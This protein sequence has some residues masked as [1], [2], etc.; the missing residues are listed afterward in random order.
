MTEV[1]EFLAKGGWLMVP[2]AISSVVALA[3]FLERLWSLQRARVL[4]PRF[5]EVMEK[6]LKERRYEEAAALCQGNDS[7]ISAVLG[8]ALRYSGRDREVVKEVMEESGQREVYFMERFVGALGAI[9]TVTP[10]MG[11]LGTVVGMITVFQRVVNQ[12]SAGQAADAGALANGIWEA[13]I[14]TAAGLTVAIPAYLA[15]RYI[16]SVIDRY[17]VEM[18]DVSLSMAEYIVPEA[19]APVVRF[20][21]E[22]AGS[23]DK[24]EDEGEPDVEPD[25]E[26]AEQEAS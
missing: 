18:V 15:Y 10:L 12:A 14:T 13:L 1:Y 7:H 25:E 4:P 5:L 20:E 16:Q 19:Q 6:L 17:A 23:S 26:P 24:S 21:D 2:I 8:A 3:F 11:L 9:A 22:A